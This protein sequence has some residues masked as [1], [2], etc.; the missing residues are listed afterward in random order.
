[1]A[2]SQRADV[3]KAINLLVP[4]LFT[5]SDRSHELVLRSVWLL[6]G[7]AERWS[8][9]DRKVLRTWV[10]VAVDDLKKALELLDQQE[11]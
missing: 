3:I 7:A 11:K 4:V 5:L 6:E 10:S 8:E 1:M 2:D 9:T